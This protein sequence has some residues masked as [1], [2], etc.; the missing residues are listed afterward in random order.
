MISGMALGHNTQGSWTL[1]LPW[2]TEV[3]G[4]KSICKIATVFKWQLSMFNINPVLYPCHGLDVRGSL[5]F[6]T[7]AFCAEATEQWALAAGSESHEWTLRFVTSP[8]FDTNS[9]YFLVFWDEA[10]SHSPKP[11][12]FGIWAFLTMGVLPSQTMSKRWI[13]SPLTYFCWALWT[14]KVINTKSWWCK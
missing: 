6:N 3:H 10:N 7:V 14:R 11:I 9:P 8:I 1:T 2:I 5:C 4:C 13:L 12:C